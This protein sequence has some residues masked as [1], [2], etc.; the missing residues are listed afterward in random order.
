MRPQARA[1]AGPA[2]VS[3]AWLFSV[4]HATQEDVGDGRRNLDEGLGGKPR[5]C[6]QG[7]G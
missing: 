3:I 2:Y 6:G 1:A 5:E 7:Q 4:V